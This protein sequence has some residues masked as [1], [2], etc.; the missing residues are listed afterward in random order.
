VKHAAFTLHTPITRG[1]FFP[2][3]I[4]NAKYINLWDTLSMNPNAVK[5]LECNPEK[6]KVAPSQMSRLQLLRSSP[7]D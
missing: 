7:R 1:K 2:G 4:E 6:I 5:F 3:S